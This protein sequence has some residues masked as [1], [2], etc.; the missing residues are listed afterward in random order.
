MLVLANMGRSG[1][2]GHGPFWPLGGLLMWVLWLMLFGLIGFM[3]FTMLRRS[4]AAARVGPPA[5]GPS[6]PT[7][8]PVPAAPV[9][10]MDVAKMRYAR[11]ELTK[12]EFEVLK[13]DLE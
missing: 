8:G 5:G 3:L 13:Q 6:G 10:A 2:F 4:D 12:E 1:R 7:G 9:S 11:G